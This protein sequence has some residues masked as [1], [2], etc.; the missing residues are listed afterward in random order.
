MTTLADR[1][2]TALLVVDVQQGNTSEAFRRD[3]VIANINALVDKARSEGVPVVWVQH[4][5]PCKNM[6]QGSDALAVRARAAAG[7]T[8]SPLVP[9]SYADSF[10]DTGLEDVLAGGGRETRRDRRGDRRVHPVH[11]PRRLRARLRRHA[12]R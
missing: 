7:A 11:A 6:P 12:R 4:E 5:D 10:E 2:L 1:S 3:E 9:K 8:R